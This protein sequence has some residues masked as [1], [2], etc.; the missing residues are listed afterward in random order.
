MLFPSSQK[1]KRKTN[2][3]ES[4]NEHGKSMIWFRSREQGALAWGPGMVG[5][6]SRKTKLGVSLKQTKNKTIR[7]KQQREK[8]KLV[9]R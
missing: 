2:Q 4:K 6:I 7:L 8:K 1:G 5:G 3:R 9:V